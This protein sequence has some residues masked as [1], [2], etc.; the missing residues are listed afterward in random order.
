MLLSPKAAFKTES[1]ALEVV[2]TAPGEMILL[3]LDERDQPD[4]KNKDILY[5]VF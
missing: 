1:D 4:S 3:V 5:T 2:V